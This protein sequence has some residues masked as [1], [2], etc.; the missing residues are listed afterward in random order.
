ME[1]HE[2]LEI[3]EDVHGEWSVSSRWPNLQLPEMA[4]WFDPLGL[5]EHTLIAWSSVGY[6]A[7]WTPSITD[8]IARACVDDSAAWKWQRKYFGEIMGEFFNAGDANC[9]RLNLVTI[10]PSRV[11][12]SIWYSQGRPRLR[13]SFGPVTL[14]D[15][16]KPICIRACH[17]IEVPVA[18]L[19]WS[20]G[21]SA[22]LPLAIVK[23]SRF[24][25][26]SHSFYWRALKYDHDRDATDLQKGRIRA[27]SATVDGDGLHARVNAP[28][29]QL[30][31]LYD[32]DTVE[33]V[34]IETSRASGRVIDIRWT[35]QRFGEFLAHDPYY[36]MPM[37]ELI[38]RKSRRLISP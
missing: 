1:H 19:L 5:D 23:G 13:E 14:Q 16:S 25:T 21:D 7:R 38:R 8:V 35:Y 15:P 37:L 26:G 12:N 9:S 34:N 10:T 4:F 29:I 17:T 6:E 24:Y 27:L 28:M 36:A 20:E 22:K 30:W 33:L 31:K 11:P 18:D 32:R 2:F 3:A